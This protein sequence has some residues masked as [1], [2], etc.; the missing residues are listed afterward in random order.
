MVFAGEESEDE[1]CPPNA[2]PR[3]SVPRSLLTR[4]PAEEHSPR[5]PNP[6]RSPNHNLVPLAQE[7]DDDDE[8][9]HDVEDVPKDAELTEEDLRALESPAVTPKCS[10]PGNPAFGTA[11]A[12][13]FD[14]ARNSPERPNRSGDF[15][16]R[17]VSDAA[18]ARPRPVHVPNTPLQRK[19]ARKL[20]AGKRQLHVKHAA[21]KELS[22]TFMDSTGTILQETS[23]SVQEISN[24]M[25]YLQGNLWELAATGITPW[26]R[27]PNNVAIPPDVFE[28]YNRAAEAS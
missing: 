13:A 4:H 21:G 5:L 7:S 17:A 23:Q 10:G 18:P 14:A 24:A 26:Q 6:F 2:A 3:A 9:L 25:R 27:V 22:S 16:T 1:V 12:D 28:K 11:G 19:I 15:A 8:W 20:A